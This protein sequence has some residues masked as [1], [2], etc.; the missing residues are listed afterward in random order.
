MSRDNFSI[1]GFN[2]IR[3]SVANNPDSTFEVQFSSSANETLLVEVPYFDF[4]NVNLRNI[5]NTRA[6][7]NNVEYS[8]FSVS[9]SSNYT[10]ILKVSGLSN[11]STMLLLYGPEA[12]PLKTPNSNNVTLYYYVII[13]VAVFIR[14]G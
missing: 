9:Q 13:V 4:Y 1:M 10:V 5:P 6:Y 14:G 3:S 12:V 11:D 2:V 7:I 8:N